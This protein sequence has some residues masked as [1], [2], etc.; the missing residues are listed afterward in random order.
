M[1]EADIRASI[2]SI[3]T[4]ILND[5][6]KNEEIDIIEE[7][8]NENT[9]RNS[10]KIDIES[11]TIIAEN[12][13]MRRKDYNIIVYFYLKKDLNVRKNIIEIKEKLS[14][15]L[16]L[17]IKVQDDWI[18]VNELEFTQELKDCIL[19]CDFSFEVYE[20]ITDEDTEKM[21]ELTIKRK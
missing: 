15:E 16:W 13:V 14:E 12:M 4:K 3:I 7:F 5:I 21:T 20:S 19:I 8:Y 17:G 11:N 1:C 6:F 10:V 9:N 18:N 2:N